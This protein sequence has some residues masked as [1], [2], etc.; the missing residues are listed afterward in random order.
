[1]AAFESRG[2]PV[3]GDRVQLHR[4]LFEDTLHPDRPV[5][6]AH[7]DC[8]WHDPVALSLARIYPHLSPG[9]YL[10]V[11]DYY[12]YGGATAAVDAFRSAHPE[13]VVVES[14]QSEH[15]LLRRAP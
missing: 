1:V 8:D 9:G 3:D 4:G 13:L 15:M 11:D 7:V 12:A 14:G 6:F 10:V 2:L 5:A